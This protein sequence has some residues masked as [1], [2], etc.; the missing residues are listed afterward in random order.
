MLLPWLL[1]SPD[2]QFVY[3]YD[4]NGNQTK[5]TNKSTNN[6]SVYTYDA[7]NRLVKVEDFVAGNPMPTATST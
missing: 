5:K 7:E 2:A 1:G 3:E 4:S 6:F